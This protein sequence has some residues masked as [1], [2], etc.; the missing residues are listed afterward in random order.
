MKLSNSK[1][2]RKILLYMLLISIFPV[3]FLGIFS[4]TRSDEIIREK[5]N[6]SNQQFLKLSQSRMEEALKIIYNY[7]TLL[8]D[9]EDFNQYLNSDISFEDYESI[10]TIQQKLID[11]Q[12]LQP[13]VLNANLMNFTHDWMISSDGINKISDVINKHEIIDLMDHNENI[14]W[15]SIQTDVT[16]NTKTPPPDLFIWGRVTLVIKMPYHLK[17]YG[18]LVV[19]LSGYEIDKLSEYEVNGEKLILLDSQNHIIS[20]EDEDLIGEDIQA[21]PELCNILLSDQKRGY[22]SINLPSEEKGIVYLKSDYNYWTYVAVYSIADITKDSRAIKWATI[23][24][25]GI[26]VFLI[27]I[28]SV[29]GSKSIYQPLNSVYL[30]AKN[31]SGDNPLN[32]KDEIDYIDKSIQTLVRSKFKLEEQLEKQIS[33]LEELFMI[34]LVRGD[35]DE[36]QVDYKIK[37]LGHMEQWNWISLVGIQIDSVGNAEDRTKDTDVLLMLVSN[38]LNECNEYFILHPVIIGKDIV[39]LMGGTRERSEDVKE[40][41]FT[42]CQKMQ[43]SIMQRLDV[44][45]S[46][47]ISRPYKRFYE[48]HIA[49][50]E[51]AE[52]LL[53]KVGFE[54]QAILFY[55]DVQPGKFIRVAY[56]K[57][58][59]E[60]L[61]SAINSAN[62]TKA[63]ETMNKMVDNIYSG[64]TGYNEHKFYINRLL[65]AIV[66]VLQDSGVALNSVFD[67]SSSII[68]EINNITQVAEIKKWFQEKIIKTVIPVLKEQR[69]NRNHRLLNEII[70]IIEEE[71][72]TPLTLEECACRLNYHPSYIW[73]VLKNEKNITFSEYLAQ[74]RLKI[75]KKWLQE[76]NLSISEIAARL[77]Y[78]NTQNFIRYFKKLEGSTP[79][80]YREKFWNE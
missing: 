7:Y 56:P 12:R 25:S 10:L 11:I 50:K 71:Y 14:F 60:E 3:I 21:V 63:I 41:V 58:L 70:R 36:Q 53:C 59:E 33:Q 66:R 27:L 8:A 73:R 6:T 28:V 57:N 54:E 15:T 16:Y 35:L 5:V 65:I 1:Y 40:E 32:S 34:K 75:A 77:Q 9:T 30:A 80:Q 17:K 26:I 44:K 62:V 64:L 76:T 74:Y 20:N 48:T 69:S 68:E 38:V 4:Y 29:M 47:G 37:T 55:G 79:G 42:A 13:L 39:L 2:W 49:Y 23:I 67:T 43:E 19:N 18:A 61:I 46:I 22:Y 52:A 45:V 31:I 78:N 24:I 51:V 72:D